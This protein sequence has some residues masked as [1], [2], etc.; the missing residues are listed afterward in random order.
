MASINHINGL[1]FAG[2]LISKLINLDMDFGG[3]GNEYPGFYMLSELR[4]VVTPAQ[5]TFSIWDLI[6]LFQAV[7]TIVQF[8]PKFRALP[9]VQDGVKYWYFASC[10]AQGLWS[11]A[12]RNREDFFP[13]L[14]ATVFMG[15]S[16]GSVVMIILSQKKVTQPEES[17]EEYWFLRFPFELTFGWLITVFL[18]NANG[19]VGEDG[20]AWAQGIMAALTIL[21][22]LIISIVALVVV[23]LPNY[24]VASV[25][26]WTLFGIVAGMRG[27]EIND[28]FSDAVTLTFLIST[29]FIGITVVGFTVYTAYKTEKAKTEST[30]VESGEY[31][32]GEMKSPEAEMA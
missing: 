22:L 14:C 32:G 30:Q 6:L 15:A 4:T 18:L 17:A 23:D 9:V 10:V 26:A 12:F 31:K 27:P 2:F 25:L 28:V 8:L 5:F 1:N 3:P 24:A 29:T 11:L 16:V 20:S 7:F 21:T 13:M 19:L